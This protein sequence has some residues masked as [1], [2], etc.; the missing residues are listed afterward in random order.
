[1]PL[2]FGNTASSGLGVTSS[3]ESIATAMGTGSSGTITF[4]SIPST[5][6]HLQL[7][8]MAQ[9]TSGAGGYPT[10]LSA[11]RL[12]N[13]TNSNYYVHRM[14]TDG[15]AGTPFAGS[16]TSTGEFFYLP[17]ADTNFYG[18]V[19]V[20]ILDYQNTNKKKVL[21]NIAASDRNGSA[22]PGRIAMNSMLWD[23][24]AA[25]NTITIVADPTYHGNW[26]TSSSFALYGIKG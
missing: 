21:R 23:S 19:I 20:D 2:L 8:I 3:Y 12:N 22:A 6:K 15:T 4:S 17:G 11:F 25:I 9:G 24:T 18:N 7:R 16:N 13:D 26:S 14:I 1:M 5:Y 10:S